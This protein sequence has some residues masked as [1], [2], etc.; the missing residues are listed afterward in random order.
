[1]K[2]FTN[3]EFD[4]LINKYYDMLFSI[5]YKYTRDTFCSEDV[6]QETFLKLY[7]AHKDFENDEHIKNWLI[8][9][10]INQCINI[11]KRNK[12]NVIVDQEYFNN[13]PEALESSEK[14]EEIWPY[15]CKLKESY[16]SIIVL[17]YYEEFSLKEIASILKITEANAAM[18]L[19]R[20]REKLKQIIIKEKDNV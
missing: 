16:K 11:S 19:D 13:L 6:V 8:R 17:Y 14:N 9:V 2:Q 20:A 10:T 12:K 15:V 7:R 5:A 4:I 18:R 1:M 3:E